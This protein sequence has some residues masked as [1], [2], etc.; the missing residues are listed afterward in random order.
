MDINKHNIDNERKIFSSVHE[1][2]CVCFK[3][4]PVDVPLNNHKNEIKVDLLLEEKQ[5]YKVWGQVIDNNQEPINDAVITLLKPQYINGRFEYY[6]VATTMSDCEGFYQFEVRQLT[7]GLR[8]KV[9]TG[10]T[11]DLM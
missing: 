11:S 6:P 8:Y 3:G 10:K 1:N 7:N 4:N 5:I 9:I 2:K